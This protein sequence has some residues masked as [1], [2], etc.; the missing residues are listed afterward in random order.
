MAPWYAQYPSELYN[1]AF[2]DAV[3]AHRNFLAGRAR[4]PKF[5]SKHRTPPAFS[6]CYTV[7]LDPGELTLSRVGTVRISAPDSHQADLR[8]KL[9]RGRSRIT[10]ARVYF[11]HNHWWAALAVE[12]E[13][14][15]SKRRPPTNGPVVGVDAG[16][17]SQ[18]VVAGSDGVVHRI[19]AGERHYRTNLAKT[20]R[21]SKTVSRRQRGSTSYHRALRQ[22]RAHQGA[23]ARRRADDLHRLTKMLTSTYPLVCVEDLAV[24]AIAMSPRLGMATMDQA[25][26]ELRRQL[27]YKAERFGSR[28]VV[29]DRFFPSSKAC[30]GCRAVKA[31]LPLD[32]RTYRCEH[33]AMVCDRDV[34]A[35]AN[36]AAYGETVLVTE[37]LASL[38]GHQI[39][40]AG[41]PDRPG[42]SATRP[43]VRGHKSHARRE[44]SAGQSDCPT[45]ET[46][47][48]EA[49]SSQ[50]LV[51]I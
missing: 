19:V 45:G 38:M 21:L 30:A 48:A 31:K 27:G 37:A 6:V 24:K 22:L 15:S 10:S 49:G 32:V 20:K 25:L 34:N 43:R 47:L 36:L 18:A 50:Q 8:R 33:C 2:R 29:A 3:A 23:I 51:R 39:T 41:D 28:V 9:R 11:R 14:S 42:P 7:K 1:F 26:G 17:K 12:Y 35:A 5:K 46:A 4:F 13:V 40:W 16:L 44:G